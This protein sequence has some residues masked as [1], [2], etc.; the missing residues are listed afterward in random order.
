MYATT[1]NGIDKPFLK[2]INKEI[3]TESELT[4]V[5]MMGLNWNK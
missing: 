5:A 3:L 2:H 1:L 4:Y